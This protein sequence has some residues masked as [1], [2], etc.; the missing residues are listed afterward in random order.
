MCG[1]D[2]NG[3]HSRRGCAFSNKNGRDGSPSRPYLAAQ[4]PL[5][6]FLLTL[7]PNLKFP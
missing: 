7:E 5:S 4:L 1:T 2:P 6:A 3:A